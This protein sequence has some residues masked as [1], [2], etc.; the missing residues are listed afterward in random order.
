MATSLVKKSTAIWHLSH[1]LEIAEGDVQVDESKNVFPVFPSGT[2]SEV[3][4]CP[5]GNQGGSENTS[6]P[7]EPWGLNKGAESV[8][9][10]KWKDMAEMMN[11]SSR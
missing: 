5:T 2:P 1:R 10:L 4:A 8:R 9:T 7:A 3:P 6:G 11:V